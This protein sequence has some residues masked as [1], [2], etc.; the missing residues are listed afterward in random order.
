[1]LLSNE[2]SYVQ[3]AAIFFFHAQNN[4][5]IIYSKIY[6]FN[7]YCLLSFI[8]LFTSAIETDTIEPHL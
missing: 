7:I 3:F 6:V 1:M 5:K 8:Y 4:N 2:I